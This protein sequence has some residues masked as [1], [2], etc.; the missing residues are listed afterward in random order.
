MQTHGIGANAATFRVRKDSFTCRPAAGWKSTPGQFR[1][2][3]NG[4]EGNKESPKSSQVRR[5]EPR[6]IA[7]DSDPHELLAL[8]IPRPLLQLAGDLARRFPVSQ[9]SALGSMLAVLGGAIGQ[10]LTLQTDFLPEAVNPAIGFGFCGESPDDADLL[11]R[12]LTGPVWAEQERALAALSEGTAELDRQIEEIARERD[13]FFTGSHIRDA[14]VEGAFNGRIA[15][16]RNL[17]KPAL[18][19]ESVEPGMLCQAVANSTGLLAVYNAASVH[20]LL[21]ATNKGAQDLRLGARSLQSRTPEA[22]ILRLPRGRAIVKPVVSFALVCRPP[23]V[24]EFACSE[25]PP[26]R[27]FFDQLLL[28]WCNSPCPRSV[29]LPDMRVWAETVKSLVL[30]RNEGRLT[31]G[32]S[33]EAKTHWTEW[34]HNNGGE[35][36][37]DRRWLY[38]V[39]TLAGKIALIFHGLER[40]R[41]PHISG[42]IMKAGFG[43]AR[44]LIRDT[45]A[46]V[47]RA[48][49]GEADAKLSQDA[50]R[51]FEK[52]R[53]FGEPVTERNLFRTFDNPRREFH[54]PALNFLLGRNNVRRLKDGR[55]QPV[56]PPP[57]T[58]L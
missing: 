54:L 43:V 50:V 58:S 16:L 27:E 57:G 46:V 14:A 15:A 47:K 1:G 38:Q 24:V 48:I 26:V 42:R 52:I 39:P 3:A 49:A 40:E 20:R 8:T 56:Q 21:R 32:L 55:L 9:V 11:L 45:I 25:S 23:T 17:Q 31:V 35:Q 19:I 33:S 5:P 41:A 4:K 34:D 28:G 53:A 7:P 51:L 36:T 44:A 29:R 10:S 22:G 6:A 12:L 13:V 18:V 2:E 37:D 30:A